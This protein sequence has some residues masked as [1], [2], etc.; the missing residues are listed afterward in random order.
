M[1]PATQL[2]LLPGLG[3]DERLLAPQ[4][5]AFPELTI[6]PWFPPAKDE[7]LASYA[8]RMAER[9]RPACNGRLVLG[10]VSFGGMLAYEMARHLKCEAVV[11]IASC[12]GRRALRF[13]FRVGCPLLPFV[14]L[15]AWDGAKLAAGVVMRARSRMPP[16]D[17][18][19]LVGMFRE[20]DSAFM[21]W[22]AQ[23]A[24]GW[25]P[26]P[27]EGTPVFQIHGRRD[28]MIPAN[29]V[30]ADVWIPDGGHLIN[31]THADRVNDFL[32]TVMDGSH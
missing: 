18:A 13:G 25:T 1:K 22:A 28:V 8:A 9:V 15:V 19:L 7:S 2:I 32:R 6:P 3:S 12:R 14:P 23:A 10:G 30:Q 31:V 20:M 24:L 26:A 21:Q 16:A 27:L 11:Q 5:R 29:R 4:R 17:R